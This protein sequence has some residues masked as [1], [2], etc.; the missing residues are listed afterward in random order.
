LNNLGEQKEGGNGGGGGGGSRGLG[1]GEKGGVEKRGIILA[2]APKSKKREG[3]LL[4]SEKERQVIPKEEGAVSMQEKAVKGGGRRTANYETRMGK[5]GG[6]QESARKREIRCDREKG[7]KSLQK[8]QKK[9]RQ[10]RRT[11]KKKK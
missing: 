5:K 11:G 1:G 7:G 9:K 6:N 8:T 2:N 3:K 10:I 4:F